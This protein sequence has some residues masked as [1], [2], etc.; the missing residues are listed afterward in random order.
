MVS[1]MS[2]PITRV[3]FE[4]WAKTRSGS[5]RRAPRRPR[6]E[7]WSTWRRLDETRCVFPHPVLPWRPRP[8][9]R[10][11]FVWIDLTT[12]GLRAQRRDGQD[13]AP[14]F[15]FSMHHPWAPPFPRAPWRARRGPWHDAVRARCRQ[16]AMLSE[17]DACRTRR[18]ELYTRLVGVWLSLVE[19]LVRDEGV[20]G[21]NP[22]TPTIFWRLA[23]RRELTA[24]RQ[25]K[26]ESS[27]R[28][29]DSVG[30]IANVVMASISATF[31]VTIRAVNDDDA[32]I[33]LLAAH[34]SPALPVCPIRRQ[35]PIGFTSA[36]E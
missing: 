12:C 22:I 13:L 5:L 2:M 4:A 16:S 10:D 26:K 21:S 24:R 11:R 17:R 28:L 20:V 23:R 34:A 29:P 1:L 15:P 3:V 25:F 19:H 36:G 14:G 9:C 33:S 27:L 18:A 35:P 8:E 32:A 6:R 30:G 31:W 7:A